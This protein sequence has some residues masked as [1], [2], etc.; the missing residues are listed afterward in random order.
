MIEEKDFRRVLGH[1]TTGVAV[2]AALVGGRPY[3]FAV[4]SFVSVSLDPPLVAYCVAHTSTTWPSMRDAGGFTVSLLAADQEQVCRLFATKGADRFGALDWFASPGGHPVLDGAL[5]W[6]EC[7]PEA[8][9]RAGDHD[10][11]VVRVTDLGDGGG[12]GD[13]PLVFYRGRFGRLSDAPTP[14]ARFDRHDDPDLDSPFFS[15]I[16]AHLD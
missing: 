5:A 13:D 10:L 11:V 4:N 14:S 7:V 12:D 2:V 16:A 9:H 8:V 3:G 15:A 1:Y 6:L